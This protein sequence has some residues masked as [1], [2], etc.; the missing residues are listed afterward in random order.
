MYENK[1]VRIKLKHG[2]V[3]MKPEQ[4]YQEVID[5]YTKEGWRF[6]Q[7]FAPPIVGNGYAT[8]YDLIFEKVKNV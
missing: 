6:V 1:V 2:I 4:D 5:K 3:E 7:I 8:F